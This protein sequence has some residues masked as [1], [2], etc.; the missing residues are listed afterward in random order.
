MGHPWVWCCTP[1]SWLPF[2]VEAVGDDLSYFF[3]ILQPSLVF[4]A[5]VGLF[6]GVG[7]GVEAGILDA[8]DYGSGFRSGESGLPDSGCSLYSEA[9]HD[10]PAFFDLLN[11]SGGI[12]GLDH[13]HAQNGSL[14]CEGGAGGC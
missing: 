13:D 1:I 5:G 9:L 11:V 8:G 6:V 14:L 10:L 7:K 12:V 2:G 4:G 3:Q